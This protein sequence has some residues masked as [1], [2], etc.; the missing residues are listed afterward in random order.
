[1]PRPRAC[2]ALGSAIACT[3][4]SMRTVPASAAWNPIKHF[5][6]V[7]LPAP[8]SPSRAWKLPGWK[9]TQTRSSACTA[10][11]RLERSRASTSG[12]G[13]AMRLAV[14]GQFAGRA[15][16]A[17]APRGGGD[18]KRKRQHVGRRAGEIVVAGDADRLQRG[19]ERGGAAEEQRYPHA[20]DRMPARENHQ[21]HGHQA[22]ATGKSLG[23]GAGVRERQ[24]GAGDA[25]A[26][27][28]H[29][30]GEGARQI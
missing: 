21:R 14:D 24:E 11:K 20:M 10:P 4:P 25:G 13:R 30:R 5:T 17:V 27:A 8:F 19:P 1:M 12:G 23:P 2:A 9:R 22:L 28:A 6:S 26:Y 29:R 16:E 15:G 7:L 18:E 3:W